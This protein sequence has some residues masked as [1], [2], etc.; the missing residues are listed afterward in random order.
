VGTIPPDPGPMRSPKP[1]TGPSGVRGDRSIMDSNESSSLGSQLDQHHAPETNGRMK[2]CRRCG[3]QT[4][5]TA[6]HHH[7]PGDAQLIRSGEWL[8]SQARQSQIAQ[9]R[10]L[11][12]P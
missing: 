10:S 11:R 3:A 6:G 4:D 12:Q 1:A 7:R 2:V 8:V 9:A 5:D